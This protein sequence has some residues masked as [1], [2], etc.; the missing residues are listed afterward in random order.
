MLIALLKNAY[1]NQAFS[2]RL[3]E[4]TFQPYYNS[5]LI[6]CQITLWSSTELNFLANK[7]PF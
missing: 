4:T 7:Y 6:T 5:S 2:H 1:L 3:D